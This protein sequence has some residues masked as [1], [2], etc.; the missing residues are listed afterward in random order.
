MKHSK[1]LV[2][3]GAVAAASLF[4]G[5]TQAQA[6]GSSQSSLQSSSPSAAGLPTAQCARTDQAQIAALFD[7][8]NNSLATLNPDKVVANYA[9]DGVLLPT[10]SNQ[11]RTNSAEIRDYF[12]HFLEKKPQGKID[13]RVIKLGCNVA[14]D[15]GTYTFTFKD[16]SKVSARYTYVYEFVNGQWLIA[17]HH[18][19]AMPEKQPS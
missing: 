2:L 15:L 5:L 4:S 3:A 18:S 16:G 1:S 13:R 14:Q 9:A 12:V 6:Q 19:S 7:R 10:V 11:P 17:H 8:W